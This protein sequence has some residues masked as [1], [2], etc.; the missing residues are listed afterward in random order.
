MSK[1]KIFVCCHKPYD[2][3]R[4]EV[5]TPIHLGRAVSSCTDE[6]RDMIGDDTGDNIS[7]KNVYYS[8]ATGIYWVWKNVHDCDYVGIHHYRRFL[9]EHFTNDNIDSYFADRTDVL[10]ARPSFCKGTN[11]FYIA[12]GCMAMEDL[13]ILRS[14]IRRKYPEYLPTFDE[15]MN[16]HTFSFFNLFVCRKSLFDEYAQWLFDILFQVEKIYRPSPYP[17]AKRALAYMSELLTPIYFFHNQKRIKYLLYSIGG[18][19]E[20]WPIKKRIKTYIFNKFILP[21]I[22][23]RPYE[24]N[25]PSATMAL[26]KDGFDIQ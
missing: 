9:A 8:E 5:Y 19:V 20:P 22:K 26:L 2:G 7:D 25:H 10:M 21:R 18:K 3:Y 14:V 4:D 11:R 16:N 23:N 13:I 24:I 1:V 6:M 15:V 17:N 12:L